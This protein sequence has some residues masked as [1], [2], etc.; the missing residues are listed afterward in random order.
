MI[1]RKKL[2]KTFLRRDEAG[3]EGLGSELQ[4]G[5]VACQISI[6]NSSAGPTGLLQSHRQGRPQ[7]LGDSCLV[8]V[9]DLARWGVE[10]RL[11]TYETRDDVKMEMKEVLV[12]GWIVVLSQGDAIG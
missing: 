4:G 1:T 9:R 5:R 3:E 7:P 11:I 10:A 6:G 12:A 2:D 8:A